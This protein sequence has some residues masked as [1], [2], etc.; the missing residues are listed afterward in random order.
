MKKILLGLFLFTVLQ[1][2]A[3]RDCASQQ[4]TEYIKS[5]G[6]SVAKNIADA[7]LFIQRRT[8]PL[9][10]SEL[11]SATNTL[12]IASSN[13]SAV[14]IAVIR[15]PV[16]VHILYNTA[17]QNISDE[18]VKSQ[19]DALNRDFR[20]KNADTINTPDRFK[21]LSADVEIEF[22][23]AT[24]D[25]K[26]R[27]T[28]GIVRKQT[29]VKEWQM[30]DRIK[31]S[32][33]GGDDAWD[34]TSYLNL[35]VGN[36]RNLLGY[37]SVVGGPMDK[38]GVAINTS[39]FGTVN[40][41]APYNMGRT[42][43]HEVGHWLGLKHIWGDT[44]CGDDLV[45][46]TPKQGGFTSGCPGG[47]RTTCNNGPLGDMYMNYMDFTN[48]AC[49]N[50]FTQGQKQRMKSLFGDGG[51][52]NTL[53]FSKGLNAPW[54][55]ESQLPEVVTTT[56]NST[57]ANKIT[58]VQL[59]PNPVANEVVLNF[60]DDASWIGKELSIRNMNGVLLQKVLISAKTQSISLNNLKPGI[61]FI[62]AINQEKKFTQKLIKL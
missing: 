52:R 42:A 14:A 43:V 48:D 28:N 56:K 17:A 59:Y 12:R 20:K 33:Q 16:V 58:Q 19:I 36:M 9:Q 44:Y 46:D 25:P 29:N 34:G 50:L 61:Y 40:T 35:W 22:V 24:A 21:S 57:P 6:G 54:M 27:A 62:Q 26:G 32:A 41:A 4:Y 13:S 60:Y 49:M 39:A 55:E 1:L 10:Q 7:E 5:S 2:S 31:F 18:Q 30:D 15:I 37:A 23:L 11:S 45:E 38:D 8:V 3:Q 47:F 53:L 51:P